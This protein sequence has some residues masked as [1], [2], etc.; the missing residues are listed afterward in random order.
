MAVFPV[1]SGRL[2]CHPPPS[3]WP[4]CG[5]ISLIQCVPWCAFVEKMERVRVGNGKNILSQPIPCLLLIV[6]V[7]AALLDQWHQLQGI[8]RLWIVSRDLKQY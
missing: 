1:V 6:D 2:S 5:N 7:D 3:I 8:F 4:P